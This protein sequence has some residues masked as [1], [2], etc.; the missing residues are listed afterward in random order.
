MA[1]AAII[2]GSGCGSRS[3][4]TGAKALHQTPLPSGSTIVLLVDTS[5]SMLANDVQPTRIGAAVDALQTFVKELPPATQ[6]GL[7]TF[8]STATTEVAPTHDHDAVVTALGGITPVGGT[9][10]GDGLAAAVQVADTALD[11]QGIRA[12]PGKPRPAE[13]VLESDGAQNRGTYTPLQGARLARQAGIRVDGVSLGSPDGEISFN[14]IGF[15]GLTIHVPPDPLTVR[16]IARVSGGIA[17]NA[18]SAAQLNADYDVI[19]AGIG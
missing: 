5:G 17:L 12:A 7:V 16:A 2:A 11:K 4:S 13:I 9:A 10:I 1:G 15:G 6:V 8:S 14:N 3:A 18:T 19:A